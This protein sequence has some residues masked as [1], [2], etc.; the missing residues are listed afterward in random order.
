M[1]TPLLATLTSAAL[2]AL[3][4]TQTFAHEC[5][6]ATRADQGNVAAGTN[7]ASWHYFG[8]LADLFNFVGPELLGLPAL[9]P[10]Q[11]A[12]AVQQGQQA[13]L[14]NTITVFERRTLLEGTP[15]EQKQAAN[16]KGVDHIVDYFDQIAAIYQQALTK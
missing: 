6:I 9:K 15:A 10:S 12:W 16:G 7:S 5:F 13:G 14:P 8:T 3:T 2:L 1:R 11:L 4:A